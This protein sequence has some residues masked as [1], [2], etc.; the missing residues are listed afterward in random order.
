MLAAAA[1]L[2]ENILR[3]TSY[4]GRLRTCRRFCPAADS[5]SAGRLIRVVNGDPGVGGSHSLGDVFQAGGHIIEY[6]GNAFRKACRNNRQRDKTSC[7]TTTSA[8]PNPGRFS[9]RLHCRLL[10]KKQSAGCIDRERAI[11]FHDDVS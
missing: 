4:A 11:I 5:F 1:I 7:A 6:G 9:L 10:R 3:H 8:L 2:F